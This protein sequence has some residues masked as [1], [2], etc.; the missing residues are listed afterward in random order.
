[1]KRLAWVPRGSPSTLA[2]GA[3]A[4]PRPWGR[5][6][7]NPPRPSKAAGSST[8]APS[9]AAGPPPPVSGALGA[10]RAL[11]ERL[12]L[13]AVARR[14]MVRLALVIGWIRATAAPDYSRRRML[15]AEWAIPLRGAW[16]PSFQA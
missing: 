15:F 4:P 13:R 11:A 5:T 9:K 8:S 16:S 6:R 10:L 14:C 2:S 1:M 3:P 12:S 7:S